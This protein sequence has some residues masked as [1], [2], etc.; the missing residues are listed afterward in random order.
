MDSLQSRTLGDGMTL[1][2]HEEES[3]VLLTP[4]LV[5]FQIYVV[6]INEYVYIFVSSP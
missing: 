1:I 6:N 4:S 5:L 2:C 3:P